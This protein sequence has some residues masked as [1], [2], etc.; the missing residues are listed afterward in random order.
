[1]FVKSNTFQILINFCPECAD[2]RTKGTKRA[3]PNKIHQHAATCYNTVVFVPTKAVY[4]ERPPGGTT[5]D[6]HNNPTWAATNGP[7]QSVAKIF[8]I[9]SISILDHKYFL[10]ILKYHPA[11]SAVKPK[12]QGRQVALLWLELSIH[13]WNWCSGAVGPNFSN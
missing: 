11:N 1:M 5:W 12:P 13:W 7:I 8:S 2:G 9:F 4:D 6:G 3:K 10:D